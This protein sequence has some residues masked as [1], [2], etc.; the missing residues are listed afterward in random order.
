MKK[1]RDNQNEISHNLK[2]RYEKMSDEWVDMIVKR[3]LEG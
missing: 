1:I 3:V 2:E